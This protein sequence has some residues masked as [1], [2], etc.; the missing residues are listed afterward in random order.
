[1][2]LR[3]GFV[4][5]AASLLVML[6]STGTL[7]VDAAESYGEAPKPIEHKPTWTAPRP[8]PTRGPHV[9]PTRPAEKPVQKPL[10]APTAKAAAKKAEKKIAI[11][12]P[13]CTTTPVIEYPVATPRP[14]IHP[15]RKPIT[16]EPVP[17]HPIRKPINPE[18]YP[19]K[20]D[21][22][23]PEEDCDKEPEP[24]QRPKQIKKVKSEGER[25]T[26]DR[27][28][29][30]KATH[31]VRFER[32]N[33]KLQCRVRSAFNE[34]RRVVCRAAN[35]PREDSEEYRS[36]AQEDRGQEIR[37][38]VVRNQEDRVQG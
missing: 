1:M 26:K 27:E 4:Q 2:Y 6:I 30:V 19:P 16:G 24:K 14:P 12:T 8:L 22:K 33:S 29:K 37:V 7:F 34:R 25:K 31:R 15:I 18:P 32:L 5:L 9:M 36:R 3:L 17:T 11:P 35:W 28:V 38:Q 13:D 21:P 23:K 10:P 20:V